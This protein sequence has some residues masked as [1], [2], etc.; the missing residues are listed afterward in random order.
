M[1]SSPEQ[2]S[3]SVDSGNGIMLVDKPSG[4]TSHDV[5]NYVRRKLGTKRVGHA[6]ILD[7]GAT[8]LLV[9]LLGRGTLL[10]VWLVGMSKRYLARFVFGV[11]TN[12]YDADGQTVATSDP[13]K[14]AP[15]DFE[16]LLANYRGEIEQPIPPYSAV[17]RSGRTFHKLARNGQEFNPGIKVVEIKGLNII[18]F[19]W[20]EVVL[21][22]QC[23]TG[24]YIRSLAY[25]MGLELGC[26]GHL[27]DLRRI[28]VGPFSLH[29]AD[30]LED[31]IKSPK[32]EQYIRPLKEALQG[33]PIVHIKEEYQDDVLGGRPLQR[34][35]FEIEQFGG[36]GEEISI[37]LG[38]DENVLALARLN[39]HWESPEAQS[40]SQIIGVYVRVIDEGHIRT[41]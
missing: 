41:E 4:M 14:I 12:T 28:E 16:K 20:P 38:P 6:G 30:T 39:S 7:P 25:Q 32:P 27:K 18:D 33:Y 3:M 24:T 21:D 34:Q 5:V 19:A 22:I 23:S 11:S 36:K 15:D 29:E 35:Y 31:I 37:L 8:G 13:G 1:K 2:W 17:K 10:S 40:P 9:M 26:G